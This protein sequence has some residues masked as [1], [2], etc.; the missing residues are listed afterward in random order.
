LEIIHNWGKLSGQYKSQIAALRANC[1]KSVVDIWSYGAIILDVL[2]GIPHWLSYKGK[3]ERN[4]KSIIKMGL[5][6]CKGRELDKYF[7]IFYYIFSRILQK[8]I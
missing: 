1:E 3:I 8:Q 2:L 5:F 7:R 4:G 6:A